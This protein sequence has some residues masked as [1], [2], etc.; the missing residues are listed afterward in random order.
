MRRTNDTNHLVWIKMAPAVLAFNFEAV[1]F[2]KVGWKWRRENYPVF[3]LRF[4]R[5]HLRPN[6]GWRELTGSAR[7][8][9]CAA[10]P[11]G[12]PA[13]WRTPGRGSVQ[14]P[15]PPQPYRVSVTSADVITLLHIKESACG[16]VCVYLCVYS[17]L[18]VSVTQWRLPILIQTRCRS[19][20]VNRWKITELT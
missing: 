3:A 1:L 13:P 12:A 2:F 9:L 11:R 4:Q 10:S 20:F 18:T 6:A 17:R 8:S 16:D 19:D 5:S 15:S 7:L 14:A